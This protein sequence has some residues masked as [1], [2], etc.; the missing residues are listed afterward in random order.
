[1]N[2]RR[3]NWPLWTGLALSVIAV[4]SYAFFFDR[5]PITRDVPWVS[6]ILLAAAIVLLIAGVRRAPG[7][8]IV[9]IIVAVIGVG[10]AALFVASVTVFSR[11]PT[12]ANIPALGA[13]APDFTL[14]EASGKP[15][16]LAQLLAEPGA[17]GVLLIFY[18]GYW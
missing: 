4:V 16:A 1:M 5:F 6:Y 9:A 18:R 10:L 8:K 12:G 11:V 15:V 13:K 17:K 7:R 14:L 2:D 3:W